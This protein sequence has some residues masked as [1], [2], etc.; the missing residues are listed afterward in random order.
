[1]ELHERDKANYSDQDDRHGARRTNIERGIERLVDLHYDA[2]RAG[3]RA[4]VG[5]DE[6]LVEGEERTNDRDHEAQGDR[7]LEQ[8]DRDQTLAL[9]PRGAVHRRR[10]VEVLGDA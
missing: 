3:P 6:E 8:G 2:L 4:A 7:P 1:M 9:P 10:L 5:D